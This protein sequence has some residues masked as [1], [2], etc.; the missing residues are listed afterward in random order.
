MSSNARDFADGAKSA[1]S[2]WAKTI[3]QKTL[4]DLIRALRAVKPGMEPQLISQ[5]SDA[6]LRSFELR[7]C[8]ARM[9][10][11]L[12]TKI[13]VFFLF[14]K[15][16]FFSVNAPVGLFGLFNI[17]NRVFSLI[18]DNIFSGFIEKSLLSNMLIGTA[19]APV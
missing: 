2:K 18:N 12:C 6:R 8:V 13:F 19:F 9:L 7:N 15:G 3:K 14:V 16:V 11:S 4:T 10:L 1:L 17:N 5:V